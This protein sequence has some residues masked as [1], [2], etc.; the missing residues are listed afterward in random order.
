MHRGRQLVGNPGVIAN[1]GREVAARMCVPANP[2]H[3]PGR[4]GMPA[5]RQEKHRD[6]HVAIGKRGCPQLLFKQGR[7]AESLTE[8]RA[9]MQAL[10]ARNADQTARL[11][12]EHFA[13]GL[14][15]ATPTAP[16]AK[17]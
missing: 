12:R 15:A 8:H 5:G 1:Q 6:H 2:G 3:I 14:A 7:I 9:V 13:N 16:Q 4:P 10:E 11:M 17:R